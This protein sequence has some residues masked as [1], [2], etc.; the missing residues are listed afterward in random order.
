MAGIVSRVQTGG[1]TGGGSTKYDPSE[2]AARRKRKSSVSAP[3]VI[4]ESPEE[5]LT[6]Q[7]GLNTVISFLRLTGPSCPSFNTSLTSIGWSVKTISGTQVLAVDT[8]DNGLINC[9]G[10]LTPVV[11]MSGFL[12]SDN[13]SAAGLLEVNLVGTYTKRIAVTYAPSGG[14]VMLAFSTIF[15]L[16]EVAS[17]SA[18]TFRIQ[19]KTSAGGPLMVVLG[20]VNFMLLKQ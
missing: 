16:S 8:T 7:L 19:I 13:L 5:Q 17:Q 6:N 3:T 14:A 15:Q 18:P 4:S 1:P 10:S 2:T 11:H 9:P 12:L 20:E